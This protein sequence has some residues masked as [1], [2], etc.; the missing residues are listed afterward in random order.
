[1]PGLRGDIAFVLR[2][3]RGP[4]GDSV[5]LSSDVPHPGLWSGW[6]ARHQRS[7]A[8]GCGPAA[9]FTNGTGSSPKI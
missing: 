4:F 1:M 2:R 7:G 5:H 9:G 8:R 3:L 6:R